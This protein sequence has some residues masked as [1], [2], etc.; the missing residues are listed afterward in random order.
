M[1]H[2]FSYILAAINSLFF[3]ILISA[4]SFAFIFFVK[5]SDVKVHTT[6]TVYV[7]VSSDTELSTD[8][9]KNEYSRFITAYNGRI[10]IYDSEGVLLQVID[11]YTKTL[12]MPDQDELQ[13]G[14]WIDSE[15]ELYSIIEAYS[16]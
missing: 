13:E 16:D 8:T 1:K 10:G 6:D 5:Q 4:V 2:K 3:L 15:K 9:D 14:F 7:Y 12:P 11:V